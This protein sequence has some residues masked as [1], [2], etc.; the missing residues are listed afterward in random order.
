[1]PK[2][3]ELLAQKKNWFVSR[4]LKSIEMRYAPQYA[5]LCC[6]GPD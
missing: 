1:M 5:L 2:A 3:D 4:N 6:W